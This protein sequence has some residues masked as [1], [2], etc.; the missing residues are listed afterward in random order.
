MT[1][2][3][4]T[5]I[6]N[7]RRYAGLTLEELVGLICV[8]IIS[9]STLKRIEHDKGGVCLSNAMMICKALD[10]SVSDIVD[11]K[12][13]LRN[14]L[15]SWYLFLYLSCQCVNH[16]IQLWSTKSRLENKLWNCVNWSTSLR[17]RN[18]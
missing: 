6:A 11:D 5:R 8:Q 9:L 14:A 3:T 16:T 7:E 15:A 17:L 12:A 1:D 2:S 4:G 10:L 13:D 18:I